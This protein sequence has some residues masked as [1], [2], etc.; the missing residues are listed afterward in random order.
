MVCAPL[1]N[2]AAET[3]PL[4][5][6]GAQSR[7]T[8]HVH[9]RDRL[10]HK[11][12]EGIARELPRGEL[13]P[14]SR[15]CYPFSRTWADSRPAGPVIK[16]PWRSLCCG[17]TQIHHP[18]PPGSVDTYRRGLSF[19]LTCWSTI[20][21][22]TV[23]HNR[24]VDTRLARSQC[25]FQPN[26]SSF[27]HASSLRK[28]ATCHSFCTSYRQRIFR[29]AV[30]YYSEMWSMPRSNSS[31]IHNPADQGIN[32]AATTPASS[33]CMIIKLQR[34]AT[35]T[36]RQLCFHALRYGYRQS[37]SR[38]CWEGICLSS[39]KIFKTVFAAT[40]Q[41]HTRC[42][43][44]PALS[45]TDVTIFSVPSYRRWIF[46]RKRIFTQIKEQQFKASTVIRQIST[47]ILAQGMVSPATTSNTMPPLIQVIDC[48]RQ[49]ML[50]V[51]SR[52]NFHRD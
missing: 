29:T 4:R 49:Y 5:A 44:I 10:A 16:S 12:A 26:S 9:F 20:N 50:N 35:N 37:A 41:L 18:A 39:K 15:Q 45:S 13:P 25:C 8:F 24:N 1:R 19:K 11:A 31:A 23:A 43:S 2:N 14:F 38:C 7:P 3:D 46:C 51:S 27:N 30:S 22:K 34:S 28:S 32:S 48:S 6:D 40:H 36:F 33:S 47:T 52:S 42:Y 21:N 17:G